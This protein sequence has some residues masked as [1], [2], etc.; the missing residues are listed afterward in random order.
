MRGIFGDYKSLDVESR[1]EE[2]TFFSKI[3]RGVNTYFL[4]EERGTSIQQEFFAGLTSFLTMSYILLVNPQILGL[5]GIPREQV[6]VSTAL[7]AAISSIFSGL[8]SNLPLGLASG[9]GL[10]IYLTYGLVQGGRLDLIESFT[11]CFISAALLGL[12]AAVGAT[13]QIMKIIPRS[14]KLGI[15]TGMGLLVA[16]VGMTSVNIVVANSQTI[17]GLGNVTTMTPYF[18]LVGLCFIGTLVYHRV[19]G[20]ILLGIA[21]LSALWWITHGT[22]PTS[23]VNLP[24]ISMGCSEFIQ[25]SSFSMESVPAVLAFLSVGLFDIS[26]VLL[27]MTELAGLKKPEDDKVEGAPAVFLSASAGS[28]FGAAFGC[29]S[30]IVYVESAAGIT[31]GGKTGLTSVFIGLFFLLSIVFAPLMS[32]VPE[33]ATAP[34]L[35]L[36]GAMMM[37]Q[38]KQV[39]WNDMMQAVPA[40][41][42]MIMMPFTF[43]ITN[44]ILFGFIS[45]L[46]F[47]LMTGTAW[48]DLK[49]LYNRT[50]D[51]DFAEFNVRKNSL[52]FE[53]NNTKEIPRIPS[54]ILD[55][56]R[57]DSITSPNKQ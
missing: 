41:L 23:F 29:T 13:E 48:S 53:N 7:S 26:G 25:F 34:V 54:L 32:S 1:E 12:I 8:Y 35:M 37:G 17:V 42:T 40:F 11:A 24:V 50:D 2:A 39:D 28:M 18:V 4:L 43:S 22:Y 45:A 3:K 46:L 14:V 51:P 20:G 30:M 55:K 15:I 44:G 47:Y 57:A 9:V 31:E 38:A 10:S 36:I 56:Q 33:A 6:V 21:V 49:I 27:G 52:S 5:I 19:R 16:L